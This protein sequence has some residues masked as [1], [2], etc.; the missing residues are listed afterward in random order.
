MSTTG[1]TYLGLRCDRHHNFYKMYNIK[2]DSQTGITLPEPWLLWVSQLLSNEQIKAVKIRWNVAGVLT[3]EE[4]TFFELFELGQDM[5]QTQ[6][7]EVAQW[8]G[9][10]EIKF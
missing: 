1:Y 3:R 4:N 7:P 5:G 8:L 10:W 2:L 9:G 6:L